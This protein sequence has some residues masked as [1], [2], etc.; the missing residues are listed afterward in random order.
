M[1]PDYSICLLNTLAWLERMNDG[2]YCKPFMSLHFFHYVK[3]IISVL[4]EIVLSRKTLDSCGLRGGFENL[5]DSLRGHKDMQLSL[6]QL[7]IKP[8]QEKEAA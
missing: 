4:R 7:R 1:L 8:L 2:G 5:N 6:P 3:I